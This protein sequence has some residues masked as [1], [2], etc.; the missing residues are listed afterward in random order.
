[1]VNH[2]IMNLVQLI[3]TI[4]GNICSKYSAC[5]GKLVPKLRAFLI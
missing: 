5:Y 4:M 1:M 3:D 2:L